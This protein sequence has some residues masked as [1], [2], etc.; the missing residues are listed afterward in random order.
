MPRALFEGKI[1]IVQ[2]VPEMKRAVDFLKT[3]TL[4]G[5]DTETRPSFQKNAIHKV[6]LLQIYTPDLCFLFRLNFIGLPPELI[7]LL[8]DDKIQRIGL[9]FH[10]D[11]RALCKRKKFKMGR[12]IELQDLVR[13]FGITDK[14][15]QKLFANLFSQRI[16]KHQRLSNWEA[17]VLTEDQKRYA[18]TDSWACVKI[19]EFL[20]HLQRTHDYQI[21]SKT[22]QLPLVDVVVKESLIENQNYV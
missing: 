15:L 1:V 18:A 22:A 20:Q 2:S 3:C 10:D 16:S 13:D 11:V 17:D 21:V 7:E 12:Y 5:L 8:Q 9:S 14:S 4:L 19:Y 6:A